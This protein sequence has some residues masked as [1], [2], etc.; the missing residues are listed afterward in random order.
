M[1]TEQS[2]NNNPK[3][4]KAMS[5][6]VADE[7]NKLYDRI[8]AAEKRITEGYKEMQALKHELGEIG[9]V[10]HDARNNINSHV[11]VCDV[12]DGNN[13]E[14]MGRIEKAINQVAKNLEKQTEATNGR[15]RATDGK[16]EAQKAKWG[17]LKDWA[18][19]GLLTLVGSLVVFIY[20]NG[21]KP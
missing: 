15:I 9:G 2:T 20:L 12:K 19:V 3:T 11:K 8:I 4:D 18:L 13:K 7:F 6:E 5:R 21:I 17:S 16:I 1:S 14:M 10:A